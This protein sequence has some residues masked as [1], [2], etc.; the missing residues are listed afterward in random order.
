MATMI[1]STIRK[2]ATV[3]E[4]AVFE[5]LK[6]CLPDDCIAYFEPYI[7]E[8]KPDYVLIIPY[9]GLL[10]L[11]V[12]DYKAN[13]ILS[14]TPSD[15]KIRSS[16]GGTSL[17]KN[18]LDQ[19][20][21]YAFMIVN[22]LKRDTALL[23]QSET[24]TG[25]LKFPYGFGVVF[26][27]LSRLHLVQ[28]GM[29]SVISDN[30]IL[31]E[32][33]I[34]YSSEDFD[35]EFFLNQLEGMFSVRLRNF[36]G[37]SEDDVNAIRYHLFPEVRIGTEKHYDEK[38][39]LKLRSLKAMS[40]YQESL[41]KQMGDGPR[42]I[43]GVAGSGKTLILVSRA[44]ILARENPDWSIVILCYSVVLSRDIRDA[45]GD[46]EQFS[47]IKVMTVNE[48]LYEYFRV[49]D[50][51][52]FEGLLSHIEAGNVGV[53]RFEAILV[54][55]AQDIE[56]TWMKI[57]SHCLDPETRSL[58]ISEDR[59]QNIFKRKTS[60][61]SDTG[62]DFRGRSR[63]LS[64]NYRNTRKVIEFA[65]NFFN[66]FS[67]PSK[68]TKELLISPEYTKRIGRAPEI[69][70]LPSYKKEVEWVS[71]KIKELVESGVAEYNQIAILYR[72]KKF[73]STDY[74]SVLGNHLKDSKIP[75]RWVSRSRETKSNYSPK[76]DE[77]KILTLDSAKGLN[78]KIVFIIA[79]HMTPFKLE[80]DSER[81]VAL[82][83]IGMT[84]ATED[85]Y[86][87]FSGD[88]EFTRYFLGAEGMVRDSKSF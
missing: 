8:R 5:C 41:A 19:A 77:V 54:D 71:G 15:W 20:R 80:E 22:K 2:S 51:A 14:A 62:L 86:I 42:L 61:L 85:L 32:D 18:P 24:V 11:E 46:S 43:R 26:T 33:E 6:N 16:D 57:I 56:P 4:K 73:G 13:T 84:R 74:I 72:V 21:D 38:D 63:V 3:G 75:C 60:L 17:A 10:V 23:E 52:L 29:D 47:N 12:K 36:K 35:K 83:Y 27:K 65:W 28:S 87:T 59:A 40:L 9:L 48:F 76:K 39:L 64:I 49:W 1:P 67:K 88:S 50:E 66:F 69:H 30:L 45:V 70:N 25:R 82:M 31:A 81:E 68:D 34:D 37:M 55:E 58:I 79:A 78:F 44:K 53:P 7:G